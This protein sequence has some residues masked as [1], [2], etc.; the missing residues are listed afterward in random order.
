MALTQ[1]YQP[2]QHTGRMFD[3]I[4]FGHYPLA[5]GVGPDRHLRA[6]CACGASVVLDPTP[7][8]EAHDGGKPLTSFWERLRCKCGARSVPLEIW[9]Q[10]APPDNG[11][12]WIWR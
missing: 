4:T 10:T 1:P 8:I 7:W 6:V 11:P 12:V 2:V 5:H 9:Y 3:A